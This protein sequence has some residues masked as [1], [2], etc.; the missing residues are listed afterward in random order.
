MGAGWLKRVNAVALGVLLGCAS[1][2]FVPRGGLLWHPRH[3]VAVP[4]L[5]S[6]GWERVKVEGADLAFRRNGSGVIAVRVRCPPPDADVPLRWEGRELWLGIPRGDME[7]F[8]LDV[9]GF[10]GINMT[11]Q[12]DDLYLRTLVVRTEECSLD[13]AQAALEPREAHRVFE[14]F[15]ARVKLRRPRP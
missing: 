7:R 12:S 8:H 11:A 15:I 1:V 5:S 2:A 14:S 13:I 10:E 9:D 6:S 4:D 3:A